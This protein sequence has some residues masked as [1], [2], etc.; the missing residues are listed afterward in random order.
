M[1]VLFVSVEAGMHC[2][3]MLQTIW[4]TLALAWEVLTCTSS[5]PR[6]CGRTAATQYAGV[7]Y[8]AGVHLDKDDLGYSAALTLE[9]NPAVTTPDAT[10]M[11]IPQYRVRCSLVMWKI[12]P[13]TCHRFV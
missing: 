3:I 2:H 8:I 11:I 7:G 6:I 1:M 13:N 9:R 12:Y 4:P 10:A 5:A